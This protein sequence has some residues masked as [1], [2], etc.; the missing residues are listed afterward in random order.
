LPQKSL[1]IPDVDGAAGPIS[2]RIV[3][4]FIVDDQSTTTSNLETK[5]KTDHLFV[6]TEKNDVQNQ[7]IAI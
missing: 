6:I 7:E 1:E 4:Q 2:C 3:E 5:R